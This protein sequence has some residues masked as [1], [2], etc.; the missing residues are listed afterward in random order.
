MARRPDRDDLF[1]WSVSEDA[2]ERAAPAAETPSRAPV[3]AD[4]PTCWPRSASAC[5]G[6]NTN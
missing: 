4:Q 3:S 2:F 6:R 5:S 1:E